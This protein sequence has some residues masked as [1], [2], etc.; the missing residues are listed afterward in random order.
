M[1]A[2]F[3]KNSALRQEWHLC[4]LS[5]DALAEFCSRLY[6]NEFLS[7]PRRDGVFSCPVYSR[8][9]RNTPKSDSW[10]GRP[11]NLC[12]NPWTN[13]NRTCS[14]CVTCQQIDSPS[15]CFTSPAKMGAKTRTAHLC[16]LQQRRKRAGRNLT[17]RKN[18]GLFLE[19]IKKAFKCFISTR[20][21][22][23]CVV[24]K[25]LSPPSYAANEILLVRVCACL[26][27]TNAL[28]A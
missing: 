28:P 27:E 2:L 17:Q 7:L 22:H 21:L 5:S 26:R 13:C 11:P 15:S 10:Q 19:S 20:D 3:L 12:F 4:K 23:P 25:R 6:Q 16:S 18:V 14:V 24:P 1:T 9:N 8:Y